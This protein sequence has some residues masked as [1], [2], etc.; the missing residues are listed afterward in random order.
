MVEKEE[1]SC[2]SHLAKL[3]TEIDKRLRAL[4]V[5]KALYCRERVKSLTSRIVELILL[6]NKFKKESAEYADV[7]REREIVEAD[8]EAAV[9]EQSSFSKIL[10]ELDSAPERVRLL[11]P[12]EVPDLQNSVRALLLRLKEA[13]ERFIQISKRKRALEETMFFKRLV[14]LV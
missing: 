4:E 6:A 1:I 8:F 9:I 2:Q 14:N 3:R 11:Q 12:D 5:H 7:K 13:N 10:E